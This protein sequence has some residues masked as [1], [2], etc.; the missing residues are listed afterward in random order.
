MSFLIVFIATPAKADEF[1]YDD[2]GQKIYWDKCNLTYATYN[3]GEKRVE[4]ILKR[5]STL[6]NK[7]FKFKKTNLNPDIEIL[8]LPDDL[9]INSGYVGKAYMYNTKGKIDRVRVEIYHNSNTVLI[10]EILHAL[11]AGHSNRI[12]SIMYPQLFGGS[13]N[14][15]LVVESVKMTKKDKKLL[16]SLTC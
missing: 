4:K 11:G 5:I 6:S 9:D 13:Y 14:G 7:K 16:R 2:S 15:K 3:L 8:Y 12:N 10:H 1:L